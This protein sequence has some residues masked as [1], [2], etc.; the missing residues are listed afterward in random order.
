MMLRLSPH[1]MPQIRQGLHDLTPQNLSDGAARIHYAHTLIKMVNSL[2]AHGARMEAKRFRDES[3][4]GPRILEWIEGED[5]SVR[6][7]PLPELENAL[8]LS[9]EQIGVLFRDGRLRDDSAM[10]YL[11]TG[12]G[13]AAFA[14]LL[15]RLHRGIDR[16]EL[17]QRAEAHDIGFDEELLD[18]LIARGVIESGVAA[19]P[20]DPGSGITWMG[21]AYVRA[22]TSSASVWFDPFPAPR[23]VWTDAESTSMFPDNVPDKF[24]LEDYGPHARQV[25]QD[26]L[27]IPNAVFITHQDTDH[28]DL[29]ALALLP[30]TVPIYVPAADPKMPWQIDLV[31]A[32]RTVLGE[33]RD[34]RVLA[35]GEKVTIGEIVVTAFPFIGEFPASLPHAWNCYLVELPDQVWA[36]CA[37]SAVTERHVAWFRERRGD[38]PRPFGIMVNGIVAHDEMQGYRD[39]SLE[40]ASFSRLY[41]WYL[42]PIRTFEPVPSCGLPI[43]VLRGL[44]TD[45]GLTQVVLYAHGNLPWYRLEG[46]FLH[47]SHVGSHALD[48]FERMEQMALS[49]GA[50]VVRLQHAKPHVA[51][52]VS[53]FP[54]R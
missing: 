53:A 35:H 44:V 2:V 29:G 47:H 12:E 42:P 20:A 41:S 50:K 32:I 34:V 18:D 1:V 9:H 4:F 36:L 31:A 16:A 49:V 28:V 8:G 40:A 33:S 22:A 48:A 11:P 37:D 26:E 19:A 6:V 7:E 45:V 54:R 27:P 24:L 30:P 38:D 3:M 43:R 13:T 14:D 46:T 51:P 10:T 5:G 39:T 15:V 23:L 52:P 21:H 17:L 25:T